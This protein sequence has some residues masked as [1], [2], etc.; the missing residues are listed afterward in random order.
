MAPLCKGGWHAEGMTGGLEAF[1]A[2]PLSLARPKSPRAPLKEGGRYF[3]SPKSNQKGP[4]VSE[5]ADPSA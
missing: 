5:A 4:L 1:P 3:L 2:L